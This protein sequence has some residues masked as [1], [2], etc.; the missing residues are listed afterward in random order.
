MALL[1]LVPPGGV[2]CVNIVLL[3]AVGR[4]TLVALHVFLK[5]SLIQINAGN[6]KLAHDKIAASPLRVPTADSLRE[7]VGYV[8]AARSEHGMFENHSGKRPDIVN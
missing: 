2:A 6:A 3:N 1:R 7:I 8:F 5:V 4:H